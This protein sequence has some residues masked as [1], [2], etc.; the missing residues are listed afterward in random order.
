MHVPGFDLKSLWQDSVRHCDSGR[1]TGV[2]F[3]DLA[4]HS[5]RV[6]VLSLG[7]AAG[8]M[9]AGAV[10]RLGD[11]VGRVVVVGASATGAPH[12][13]EVYVGDHPYPGSASFAAGR[14]LLRAAEELCREDEKVLVLVSGGGSAL[15]EVAA[16]GISE[17]ELLAVHKALVRSGLPIETMNRVRSRLSAIKGGGLARALGRSLVWEGVLVDIPSGDPDAVASGPCR[18]LDPKTA[19]EFANVD[20]RTIGTPITL[21]DTAARLASD[22]G[23]EQVTGRGG[24]VSGSP[25]EEVGEE[26]LSHIM[27]G[28]GLLI[29][30]GEVSVPLSSEGPRGRGGR[31]QHLAL[32]V[33]EQAKQRLPQGLEWAFLAAGSDGRDGEGAAGALVH[34]GCGGTP[35]EL[36]WGLQ[37]HASGEIH[38]RLGTLL[39][40][41]SPRTNLTDL[42]MAWVR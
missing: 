15:C 36:R 12:G 35:E 26:V 3:G 23:V 19:G 41:H 4:G 13:A 10:E 2:V 28:S 40:E 5:T 20:R 22:R 30:T 9:A 42:Y 17:E 39:E 24:T 16:E 33:L 29:A 7:K 6:N 21:A 25:V 27:D 1:L 34:N 18:P 37:H 14:A 32:W 8:P 11:G 38:R 31:A